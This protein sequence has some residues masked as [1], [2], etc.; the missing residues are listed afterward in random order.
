MVPCRIQTLQGQK[1]CKYRTHKESRL[2]VLYHCLFTEIV[3]D[4]GCNPSDNRSI[5]PKNKTYME[6]Y[7]IQTVGVEGV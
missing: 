7:R 6:L 5:C 3:L 2:F 1:E 4:N